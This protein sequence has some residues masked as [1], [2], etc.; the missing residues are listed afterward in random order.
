MLT[1]APAIAGPIRYLADAAQ[2]H[3]IPRGWSDVL[4]GGLCGG[5][6]LLGQ[7]AAGIRPDLTAICFLFGGLFGGFYF[8]RR[9]GYPGLAREELGVVEGLYRWLRRIRGRLAA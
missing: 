2:C 3:G 5:F 6:P 8:W 4:I 7:L 1:L 9:R